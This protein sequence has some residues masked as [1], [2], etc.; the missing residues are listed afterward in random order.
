MSNR[1]VPISVFNASSMSLQVIVNNGNPTSINGTGPA[2][3]WTPQQPSNSWSF[4][5]GYPSPNQFGFGGNFIQVMAGSMSANFQVSI[6]QSVQ[7]TS[8]QLYIFLSNDTASW[9]LLNNGQVI[10]SGQG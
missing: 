1:N 4:N 3:N 5:N 10:G 6:P 7:I 9:I 2:Q 8:L